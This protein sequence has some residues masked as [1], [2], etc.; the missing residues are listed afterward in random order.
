MGRQII[1]QDD[2]ARYRQAQSH[3]VAGFGA[4]PGIAAAP[5]AAAAPAIAAAVSQSGEP[6]ADDYQDRLLKLIPTEVVTSYIFL[7]GLLRSAPAN[8]PA[9][10]LRWVVFVALLVAT[11][12]YLNRIE[13]VTK[14]DQLIISTL[15][16]ALWVFSLGGPF[17]AFHWYSPIYGAVLL[18]LYTFGVAIDQRKKP[19]DVSNQE[20]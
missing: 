8:V 1:T 13:N 15:A 3:R 6:K 18:P 7:D 11:W 17:T 10:V 4:A 9:S 19:G 2:V 20:T 16:F 12:F 5:A 14:R